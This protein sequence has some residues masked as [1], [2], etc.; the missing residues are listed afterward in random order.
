MIQ[1]WPGEERRKHWRYPCAGDAWV[2]T[3]G[4]EVL[5]QGQL[6]D[7]SLGG[8]YLDMMNPLPSE[9]V[10][11]L[12]LSLLDRRVRARGTVRASRQGFGMGI[13]FT[14]GVGADRAKLQELI[15]LLAGSCPVEP[16]IDGERLGTDTGTSMGRRTMH[17]DSSQNILDPLKPLLEMLERKGVFTPEERV[18]LSHRIEATLRK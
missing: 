12:T 14:E 9:T 2:G 6:S 13:A 18:E 10:V 1:T 5:L 15:D 4:T 17:L 7:I 3:P 11:E 16:A 8:C